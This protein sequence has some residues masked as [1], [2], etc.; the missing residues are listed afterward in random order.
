M[1]KP[2]NLRWSPGEDRCGPWVY[3]RFRTWELE[4]WFDRREHVLEPGRDYPYDAPFHGLERRLKVAAAKRL[5]G[6]RIWRVDGKVHVIM[7]SE[8]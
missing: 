2:K 5:G 3:F 7:W 1:G 4:Q 6:A 8:D